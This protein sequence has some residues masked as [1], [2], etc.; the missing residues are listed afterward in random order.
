MSAA[1]D[2][3]YYVNGLLCSPEEQEKRRELL[4]G[5][6]QKRY[7]GVAS[8]SDRSR[9][10]SYQDPASI[11]KAIKALEDEIAICDGTYVHR[12][13]SRIRFAPYNKWL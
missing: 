7:S 8:V 9:S 12:Q 10:V 1:I 2:P 6:K 4:D 3:P 11:L 5:L 13:R